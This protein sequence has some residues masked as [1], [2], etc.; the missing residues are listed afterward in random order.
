MGQLHYGDNRSFQFDDHTL[1]HLRTVILGKFNLQES[2][3]F[4]WM[5]GTKQ[6]S[7]WLHPSIPLYFEFDAPFLPEIDREWVDRLLTDANSPTGL[8]IDLSAR[9]SEG[10]D[11]D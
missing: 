5:D 10:D 2:I 1:S 8:R 7:L 6:H 3:V 4:S 11:A 9:P